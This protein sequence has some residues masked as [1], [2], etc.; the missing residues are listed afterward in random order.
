MV[1][2]PAAPVEMAHRHERARK[3]KVILARHFMIGQVR[4]FCA[5]KAPPNLV[6]VRS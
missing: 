2:A 3:K 6:V 5:N 1:F 4:R